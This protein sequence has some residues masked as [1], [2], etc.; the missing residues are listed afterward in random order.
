MI[1]QPLK[2][3]YVLSDVWFESTVPWTSS[4]IVDYCK[5]SVNCRRAYEANALSPCDMP[6]YWALRMFG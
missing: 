4:V 6:Y 1:P 3:Q 5:K 2:V